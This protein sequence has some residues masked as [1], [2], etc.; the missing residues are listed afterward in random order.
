MRYCPK[1]G[2]L[3][4]SLLQNFEDSYLKTY[5][6]LSAGLKEFNCNSRIPAVLSGMSNTGVIS[7]TSGIGA[8]SVQWQ[9][10]IPGLTQLILRIGA[11]GLKKV[12]LAGVN[13]HT[14]SCLLMIGGCTP[15]STACR[16]ALLR[17]RN[18]QRRESSGFTQWWK[19]VRVQILSQTNSS[20]LRQE[21]MSS[22]YL[23][24][25][26]RRARAFDINRTRLDGQH[27]TTVALRLQAR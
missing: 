26:I 15:A 6:T 2:L 21:R 22:L 7:S 13:V 16:R 11:R 4:K 25:V 24:P 23:P 19:S 8:R 18:A 14:L 5:C 12:A 3:K 1:T 17:C 20:R 9:A 10:D 27:P